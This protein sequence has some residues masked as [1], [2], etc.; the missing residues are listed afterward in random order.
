[1]TREA[2]ASRTLTG[3][4]WTNRRRLGRGLALAL[5]RS[6]AIAPCPW[7][8]QRMIDVAVPARDSAAIIQLG[9]ICLVLL[10][11]HYVFS[12]WGSCEI[13]RGLVL[14]FPGPASFTGEDIV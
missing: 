9:V 2:L 13:D 7:L 11:V 14:A 10:G 4:L 8:F 6:L 12:V 1:M 5:L 3:Y